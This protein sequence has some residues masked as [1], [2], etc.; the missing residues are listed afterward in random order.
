[1]SETDWTPD[2]PLRADA[3]DEQIAQRW[4]YRG[5][6]NAAKHTAEV[7]REFAVACVKKNTENLKELTQIVHKCIEHLSYT[8][9]SVGC[10]RLAGEIA[11]AVLARLADSSTSP[12]QNNG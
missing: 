7:A 4:L 10:M 9:T 5:P 8:L 12:E 1:M 3:T 11:D 2:V 6:G